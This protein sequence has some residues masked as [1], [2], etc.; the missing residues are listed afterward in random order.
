MRLKHFRI[1]NFRNIEKAEIVLEGYRHFFCGPNGQGKTN[2]LEAIGLLTAMRSFRTTKRL[3][4]IREEQPHANVRAEV[5]MN[6]LDDENSTQVDIHLSRVLRN[7]RVDEAPIE[8]FS[9]FLGQFPTVVFS[10]EDIQLLRGSPSGRRR[11]FDLV[12]SFGDPRYL[13]SLRKYHKTLKQRNALLKFSDPY[14]QIPSFD[15]LLAPIAAH[16]IHLRV[17][18]LAELDQYLKNFYSKIADNPAEVPD[19]QYSQ[20]K[21]A[22]SEEEVLDLL[23]HN[24]ERDISSGSTS[25]GPHRDDFLFLFNGKSAM[26][27][28]SEGQQRAWVLSLRFAQYLY[29]REK[30]GTDPIILADDILGELDPERRKRFWKAIDPM[31]QVIATGTSLPDDAEPWQTFSVVNGTFA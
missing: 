25:H 24:L 12:L 29:F 22:R 16:L 10:S 6:G 14:S 2:M 20:A 31:T 23:Q 27:F 5:L 7:A 9:D 30:S 1:S 11:F 21:V 19:L 4:L 28:A 17:E 18:L 15:Q 13:Q 26:E 3:P 8:K